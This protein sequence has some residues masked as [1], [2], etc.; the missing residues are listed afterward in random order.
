MPCGFTIQS[1]GQIR[2]WR[3]TAR[4]P[5]PAEERRKKTYQPSLSPTKDMTRTFSRTSIGSGQRMPAARSRFRLRISFSA[6][7]RT[8]LRGLWRLEKVRFEFHNGEDVDALRA[9]PITPAETELPR[10]IAVTVF[11]D[12]NGSLVDLQSEVAALWCECVVYVGLDE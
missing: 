12:Q 11:K 9:A 2:I 10:D 1:A 6:Q 4:G 3:R 7:T 8:I 5:T